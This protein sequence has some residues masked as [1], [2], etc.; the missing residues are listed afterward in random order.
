MQLAGLFP[1]V[2]LAVLLFA[3]APKIR[4]PIVGCILL[5]AGLAVFAVRLHHEGPYPF[6]GPADFSFGSAALLLGALLVRSPWSR[7][8]DGD[9]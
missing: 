1:W 4:T 2:L 6:P 9:V 8:R 5:V 7:P 3:I